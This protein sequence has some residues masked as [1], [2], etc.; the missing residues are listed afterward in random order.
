MEEKT[1]DRIKDLIAKGAISPMMRLILTNAI[2]FKAAWA[3]TFDDHAT[4][5]MPFHVSESSQVPVSMMFRKEDFHYLE[6]DRFQALE[7]PYKAHELSMLVFLPKALD[8]LDN[9]EKSP[10]RRHTGWLEG[11]PSS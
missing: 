1:R 5:E 11:S 6:T 7:M 2:Y 3:E 4:R 10:V 9:L 8:G